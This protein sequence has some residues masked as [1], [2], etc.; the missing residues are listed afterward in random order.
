MRIDR[1][2]TR[3]LLDR[4]IGELGA[5]M[6]AP[7][8]VLGDRLGL[9]RELAT[10]PLT[11]DALAEATDTNP[12]YVREW[13]CAQ[14]AAGFVQ[15]DP[16]ERTFGLS[17]EQSEIFADESSPISMLGGF[18]LATGAICD[19]PQLLADFRSGD[20]IGWDKKHQD[21]SSGTGRF[22]RP[23]YAS[24]LVRH[25]LAAMEGIE[26]R[27]RDGGKVADVG[28]GLG[29][30]TMLMA[31]AF[32][33]STFVGFDVHQ[34]SI[35]AARATCRA[36]GLAE[37]CHFEVG[38]ATEF[39][40]RDWDLVT[41]LNCLHDLGDPLGAARHVRS[42][43]RA[44]GSW[45]IVEPRA[46]DALEENLGSVGRMYYAASTLVCTPAS[47]SES[48]QT[49][50]GAQAG[51]ARLRELLAQAGFEDVRRVAETHFSLVLEARRTE[52][53]SRESP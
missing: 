52:K 19:Y 21:V 2:K 47:L 7:L 50:L 16:T 22:F 48:V 53:P 28:C 17:P 5:A 31:R 18:E 4:I 13:L 20:G 38:R 29:H 49:A 41:F 33:R 36:A 24:H 42:R 30:S 46:G 44:G 9:F 1:E 25:W 51:E 10:G 35:E 3:D 15:F 27:L 23:A 26:A 40:G 14:V 6:T 34:K 43:L 12:R 45:M 8:V 37:R 39:G 32:P 11:V